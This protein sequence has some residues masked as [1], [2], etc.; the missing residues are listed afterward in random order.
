[1]KSSKYRL[2]ITIPDDDKTSP[3]ED[4]KNEELNNFQPGEEN[5]APSTEK[6]YDKNHLNSDLPK[7]GGMKT[8]THLGQHSQTKNI[9]LNKFKCESTRNNQRYANIQE[10]HELGKHPA[11]SFKNIDD[12][13][14][15]KEDLP[16]A[17]NC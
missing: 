8:G 14:Q 9:F 16:K 10:D 3:P 5:L 6:K 2:K 7:T 13:N 15:K 17:Q 1:M 12:S 11:F 4:T